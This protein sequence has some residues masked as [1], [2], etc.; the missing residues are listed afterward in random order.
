MDDAGVSAAEYAQ[1]AGF[2]DLYD[3]MVGEG[4]RTE[5]VIRLLVCDFLF[6]LHCCMLSVILFLKKQEEKEAEMDAEEEDEEDE[7]MEEDKETS[8]RDGTE[9]VNKEYLSSALHYSDDRLLDSE[10]NAVM[11]GWETPIMEKSAALMCPCEGRDVINIG[12]GLGIIDTFLQKYHPRTHTIVEAHPDGLFFPQ[13]IKKTSYAVLHCA[14]LT[15]IVYRFM[16]DH[17]WDKKPGVRILF[18]RWQDVMPQIQEQQYDAI[19]FDTFGEYYKDLYEFN[20]HVPALLKHKSDAVYSFFNG[21]AGTNT[22]FHE[23]YC[24]IAAMDLEALGLTTEYQ[25]MVIPKESVEFVWKG[26]KRAYWSLPIYNLPVCHFKEL[27]KDE[28]C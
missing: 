6:I 19:Y 4:I 2:Q 8:A 23:V 27:K 17:G 16:V 18:G 5:L 20:K 14:H 26:V 7:K 1:R 9:P 22:F 11:M 28:S 24:I 25:Q 21:L 3:F 12:F 10:N 15:L 13:Q